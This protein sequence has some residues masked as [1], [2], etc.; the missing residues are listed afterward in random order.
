[1]TKSTGSK[2]E[3]N[4]PVWCNV[5]Q[6]EK[7]DIRDICSSERHIW[8]NMIYP[9][10]ENLMFSR[11]SRKKQ[12]TRHDLNRDETAYS[13]SSQWRR[14]ITSKLFIFRVDAVVL[15]TRASK[16]DWS[17]KSKQFYVITCSDEVSTINTWNVIW[18]IFFH[19]VGKISDTLHSGINRVVMSVKLVSINISNSSF[20][21]L[22][23]NVGLTSPI[24]TNFSECWLGCLWNI[25]NASPL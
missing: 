7:G 20:L 13:M 1:M 23:N 22:L 3:S 9:R 4:K 10:V 14:K 6:H 18:I 24:D 19:Y 2:T 15:N 8:W 11:N 25:L 12:Q 21:R 5:T 16:K 17:P